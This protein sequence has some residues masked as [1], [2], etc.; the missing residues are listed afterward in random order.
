MIY[1]SVCDY[2]GADR[3]FSFE[4]KVP[5]HYLKKFEVKDK[6]ESALEKLISSIYSI[7]DDDE[8]MRKMLKIDR[9]ARIK[10]FDSLR[11]N[12]PIRREFNNYSVHADNLSNEQK[13]I[14]E[15]LPFI[16]TI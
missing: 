2:L 9:E 12:Y 3:N 10:Y 16:L 5:Q 7:R 8:R 6:F 4:K 13:K 14:L 15:K 11:K 1:N